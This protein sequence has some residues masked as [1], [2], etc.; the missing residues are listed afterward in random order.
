V[1]ASVVVVVVAVGDTSGVAVVEPVVVVVEPV[2]VAEV[3]PAS[4]SAVGAASC[5]DTAAAAES[6]P[7]RYTSLA[8]AVAAV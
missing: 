5:L 6:E 4:A 7:F 8:A 1:V 2:V 3:A